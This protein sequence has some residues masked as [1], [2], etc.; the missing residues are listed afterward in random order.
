MNYTEIFHRNRR[1]HNRLGIPHTELEYL[2]LQEAH[3]KDHILDLIDEIAEVKKHLQ[4][5]IELIAAESN[6]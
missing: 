2:Q 5:I 3:A 4:S 1:A 6:E